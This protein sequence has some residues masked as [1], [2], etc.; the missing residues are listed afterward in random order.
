MVHQSTIDKAVQIC[1]KY[2]PTKVLLF[3]SAARSAVED[4]NDVDLVIY[5]VDD[6]IVRGRLFFELNSL[7]EPVDVI[8]DDYV[9]EDILRRWEA[10]GIIL[11]EEGALI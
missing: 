4:A 5:G 2:H 3:G 1:K 8:F 6:N 11:F 10:E 7:E 9:E